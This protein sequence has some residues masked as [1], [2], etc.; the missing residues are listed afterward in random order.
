LACIAAAPSSDAKSVTERLLYGVRALVLKTNCPFS[1]M[2]EMSEP[3]INPLRASDKD[4]QV[5]GC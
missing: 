2:T 4:H 3:D 1:R 5:L